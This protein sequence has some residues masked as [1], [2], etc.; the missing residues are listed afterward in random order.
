[1]VAEA[2]TVKLVAEVAELVPSETTTLWGPLGAA[3]MVKVTAAAPLAP[4]VPP[5]VIMAEVPLTLT[6][7]A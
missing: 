6:V 5:E 1:M 7:R 3:G 4:V 2:A